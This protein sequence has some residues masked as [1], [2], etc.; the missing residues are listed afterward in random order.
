[1]DDLWRGAHQ[2]LGVVTQPLDCPALQQI[3]RHSGGFKQI[4]LHVR[5]GILERVLLAHTP[6]GRN[7]GPFPY[8]L[9]RLNGIHRR[10]N[11]RTAQLL[12]Q[13]AQQPEPQPGMDTLAR[14]LYLAGVQRHPG[15]GVQRQHMRRGIAWLG[16]SAEGK[17]VQPKIRAEQPQFQ[18]AMMVRAGEHQRHAPDEQM[19]WPVIG[20]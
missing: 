12:N 10:D 20:A 2:Q 6:T 1:M 4:H 8:L 18:A 9:K 15:L 11:P 5:L 19:H 7:P 14:Q 17:P 13:P 3:N 16:D